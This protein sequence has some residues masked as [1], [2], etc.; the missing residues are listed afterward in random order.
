MCITKVRAP[1]SFESWLLEDGDLHW[2][3]VVSFPDY[4][5]TRFINKAIGSSLG[6]PQA[7]HYCS[8]TAAGERP[9]VCLGGPRTEAGAALPTRG[10]RGVSAED[11][12]ERQPEGDRER[13]GDPPPASSPLFLVKKTHWSHPLP[14]QTGE[15]TRRAASSL[16]L[17]FIPFSEL[18]SASGEGREGDKGRW[19]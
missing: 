17:W 7:S 14:L 3:G 12:G 11:R 4:P 9:A 16:A 13:N 10:G 2:S 15:L 19:P 18:Y 1:F 5:K 6:G 8:D